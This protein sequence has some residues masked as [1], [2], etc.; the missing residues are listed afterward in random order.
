MHTPLFSHIV[1]VQI[2]KI[3]P[4]KFNIFSVDKK[5]SEKLATMKILFVSLGLDWVKEEY[6]KQRKIWRDMRKI[7]HQVTKGLY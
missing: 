5:N 6:D 1:C 2:S 7:L 3:G 4:L